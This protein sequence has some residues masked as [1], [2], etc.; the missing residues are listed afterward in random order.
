M[1]KKSW[2]KVR[3][4]VFIVLI[5]TSSLAC[6]LLTGERE[7]TPVAEMPASDEEASTL[8]DG[9]DLA[10]LEEALAAETVD[11]RPGVLDYLGPPDA[12]D[13]A[14]VQVEGGTVRRESWRYY[15]YAT[16]VDFVDGEAV[17]TM[18][19][20]PMPEGTLFAAWYDPLAFK[21]GMTGDEVSQVAAA[22]S[23][24]GMVP[25]SIDLSEGGDDLAGGTALIGDQIMIG[26]HEDRLVYV[27]TVAL[28]PEGGV[29]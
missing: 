29:E 20:E 27:E 19:I 14:I 6:G 17:L 23:P 18:E 13:I 2:S 7:S 15:Q 4:F 10:D 22:A 12:F 16:R 3:L 11:D 28:V 1:K 26:L 8:D 5:V 9:V 25:E 24:A 21:Q